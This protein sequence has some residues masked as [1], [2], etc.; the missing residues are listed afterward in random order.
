MRSTRRQVSSSGLLQPSTCAEAGYKIGFHLDPMI[1][2]PDWEGDYRDLIDEIFNRIPSASIPWI[3]VG[4]LRVTA[5][6]KKHNALSIPNSTL[7]LGELVPTDDGKM[8]YFRP[9]RVRMYQAVLGGYAGTVRRLLS[10]SVW[11]PPEC[12]ARFSPRHLPRMQ[13]SGTRSSPPILL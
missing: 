6:V 1:D 3:S 9:K 12:G 10:T 11:S 2:Y 8:R 5:R 4:T 7:T 13:R